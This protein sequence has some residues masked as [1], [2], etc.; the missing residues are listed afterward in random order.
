MPYY[1]PWIA[2]PHT[3]TAAITPSFEVVR[4]GS[5]TAYQDDEIWGEWMAKATSGVPKLS[6]YNDK[7]ALAAPL[8]PANQTTGALAAGDWTGE[9]GTAWFGKLHTA[10]TITPAEVGYIYGRVVVGEPSITVY[11]DPQIRIT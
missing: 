1:G 5:A 8:S 11:Y 2:K 6:F 7:V 4:D 3:G 10:S 9:G